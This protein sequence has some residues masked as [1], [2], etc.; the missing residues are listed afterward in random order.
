MGFEGHLRKPS[1]TE[2]RHLYITQYHNDHGKRGK[3]CVAMG[4]PEL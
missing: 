3:M 4:F 1:Q 2:Y